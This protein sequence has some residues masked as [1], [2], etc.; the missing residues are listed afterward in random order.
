MTSP[1]DNAPL[2]AV[3]SLALP[4][5]LVSRISGIE[6]SLAK[7]AS[8]YGP[9]IDR[10]LEDQRR[11]QQSLQP[12]AHS[13][14]SILE[15][16]NALSLQPFAH[17]AASILGGHNAV[18]LLPFVHSA[19]S[20]LEGHSAL[21]QSLAGTTELQRTLSHIT[22]AT[23]A[24]KDLNPM[25]A[26][27]SES[28]R[29]ASAMLSFGRYDSITSYLVG[30]PQLLNLDGIAASLRT[31]SEQLYRPFAPASEAYNHWR[32]TL[33][34]SS[35][36]PEWTMPA[37]EQFLLSDV[38]AGLQQE[39]IYDVQ[40]LDER[41]TLVEE[42]EEDVL[43]SL[44]DALRSIDAELFRL[45]QG[46]WAAL[47]STTPDKIRHGM[48]SARELVTHVL[49]SLAPDSEVKAWTSQAEHFHNDR[50]TRRARFLFIASHIGG[51][52][53]R[54]YIIKEIDACL[55]LIDLFQT[56]THAINPPF[57]ERQLKSML[58]KVHSMI[59]A[60][61]EMKGYGRR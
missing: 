8:A 37:R 51:D 44:P 24:F 45:W 16:N 38:L 60:L 30:A 32:Q 57:T 5:D 15:G 35:V 22:D 19:A 40:L 11:L 39:D 17:S 31:V 3:R 27:V 12:F 34:A 10:I 59:C 48:T 49:H 54:D 41:E 58:R 14:A 9:T 43:I 25:V 29:E 61:V 1:D 7:M 26:R 33:T 47:A 20:I 55:A 2:Q 13:A 46:A 50:P 52:E 53:L 23:D 56:G 4:T 6:Q 18:S 21:L 36:A 42:A 28:V